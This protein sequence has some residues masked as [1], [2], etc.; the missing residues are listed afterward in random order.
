MA[1]C[2][3]QKYGYY[4]V[5]EHYRKTGQVLG[6][7]TEELEGYTLKGK[8]HFGVGEL[9]SFKREELASPGIEHRSGDPMPDESY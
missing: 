6:K 4:Q 9:P 3:I 8:G 2:P 7:G 1:V 5:M